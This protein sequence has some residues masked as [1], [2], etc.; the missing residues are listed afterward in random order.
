MCTAGNARKAPEHHAGAMHARADVGDKECLISRSAVT[1][2]RAGRRKAGSEAE[3][4]VG[5][6]DDRKAAEQ[7][8]GWQARKHT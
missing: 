5:T 4:E 2:L 6:Q 7:Q 3:R 1:A 8:A